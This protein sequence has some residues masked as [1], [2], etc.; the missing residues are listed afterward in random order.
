VL[1]AIEELV[2]HSLVRVVDD[3]TDPRFGLLETIREYAL[4]VLGKRRAAVETAMASYLVELLD[5]VELDVR[6]HGEASLRRVDP[7]IDNVRVAIDS[8]AE[9]GDLQLE[10]RLAS[11]LWRYCWVRGIAPEG[12]RRIESA[13]ERA[14]E[15]ATPA[16]ARALQGGAGLAWSLRDFER[17]KAL[18]H[19]AIPVAA[20]AGSLLD[21]MTAN[22]VLGAVA[23]N[24]GDHGA[25]R[26]HHQ[27]SMEI[28]EQLGFEPVVQKLNLGVVAMDSG[29]FDEAQGLLED[30][31]AVHRRND[32]AS[33]IG[34][35]SMNLGVVFY[36]L[37]HPAA[38]LAAF[39]EAH[40][41]FEEVGFRAQAANAL[42]GFAAFEASEGRFEE[43]ARMLGQ[44]RAVCDEVGASETDFASGMVAWIKEQARVA[45]GDDGFEAAYAAGR[46]SAG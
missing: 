31:L 2:E 40:D 41:R 25:A 3:C 17:A 8:C 20:E 39:K 37:G 43:A 1:E 36:A 22:T 46:E 14:D 9:A 12:L 35:A 23:N 18:A 4:E 26:F 34:F 33:G 21:E 45:L 27:R 19:A 6:V 16:R 15:Q 32:N 24:E 29:E 10:L 38:S 30:V 28:A 5:A 44:A 7:E 42:Q 13:L 11:G